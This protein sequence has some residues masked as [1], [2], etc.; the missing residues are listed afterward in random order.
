MGSSPLR[1]Q[2]MPEIPANP[3]ILLVEDES[4]IGLAESRLLAGAGFRVELAASGEEAVR[5]ALESR[6][7]LVLMD[8]NLG[9][10]IDGGEAAG[11]IR[12][13]GGAPVVFLSSHSEE[14]AVAKTKD[15]GGYGYIVKNTGQKVL[16]ASVRMA[17]GLASAHRALAESEERWESLA[18]TA[19]DLIFSIGQDRKILFMNRPVEGRPASDCL[20]SDLAELF[21]PEERENFLRKIERVF[22]EGITARQHLRSFDSHGELRHYDGYLGPVREAGRVVSA[23]AVLR[24]VTGENRLARGDPLGR[25][26]QEAEVKAAMDGFDF[27]PVRELLTAFY[28][29]TGVQVAIISV[30]DDAYAETEHARACEQF[31]NA[32]VETL[33]FCRE[34]NRRS[35]VLVG[36][37]GAFAD[38]LCPNGI[39][40]ISQPLVV[41]G[42]QWATLFFG[43]FLYDDD[44]V[45]E[46]AFASR[47]RL[48]GW[49]VE[50]Y[51]AAVREVPRYSRGRVAELMS[52]LGPLGRFVTSLAYGAFKERVLSRHNIA[53]EAALGESDKRYRL[54]AENVGDVI[55]TLD[56]ASMRFTYVSPS[57]LALRGM[58]VEEALVEPIE[59]S[60]SPASLDKVRAPAAVG[61]PATSFSLISAIIAPTLAKDSGER[62]VPSGS[63]RA[64]STLRPRSA[65]IEGLT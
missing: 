23:T 59:D 24:D 22:R 51:L 39:R 30:D 7:D 48:H 63:A 29:L 2:P 10:G 25:D 37:P 45:D 38:Y 6:F 15:S 35:E 8:I 58:S 17:L 62:D 33:G 28:E 56:P 52:F 46:E 42:V 14:E 26:Q 32:C 64:S 50:D 18:S 57:I 1:L 21:L 27:T 34:S 36:R 53:T 9:D 60:M 44:E 65:V 40:D 55:W 54:L 13:G 5:R 41:E 47:A 31:H 43:Q 61:S 16:I 11:L 4:I 49:D 3:L 12:D 19:P 20:G